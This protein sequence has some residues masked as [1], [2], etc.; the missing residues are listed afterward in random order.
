MTLIKKPLEGITVVDFTHVLSGPFCAMMLADQGARIIKIE[1]VN[2]GDDS[3]QF[4]PFYEDGTSVYYYFVNRG[5]ESIALNLKNP[6]DL[7]LVKEM[8]SKSD[9]VIENFRPGT[10]AKLGMAPETLVAENPQ[11]IVCSI[12][13]FGQTGPMSQEPAYDTVV[14]ALSGLMSVTGFPDGSATRVGTSIGDLSAGLFAY[15][16]ITTALFA[17]EKTGKGTTIDIS[18]LD[19]LFSLMEHGLM[20]SLALKIDPKR[21]GNRHPS[22]TPFD[23]F[24]CQDRQLV[25]CCGNDVLFSH[26]CNTVGLPDLP[27]D[28]RFSTNEK[29]NENQEI[30]KELLEK[31][32]MTDTAEAWRAKLETGGIPVGLVLSVE[33]AENLPQ[34]RFRKMVAQSGPNEVP[35]NPLKFGAYNSDISSIPPPALDA[36]GAG[37]RKEFGKF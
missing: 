7:A 27:K 32:L 8:I 26:L 22:I 30:L 10:M 24:N 36:N 17:R 12:S 14:Q 25:I 35:G 5:K 37:I 19:G 11:L 4:G 28:D 9:V 20:D 16:A 31:P 13:G 1:R 29:R 6:D 34:I 21:I 33:E 3:R 23:A 2:L 15:A 18:M